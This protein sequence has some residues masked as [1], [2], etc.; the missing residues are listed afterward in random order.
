MYYSK[1]EKMKR[2]LLLIL[3]SIIFVGCGKSQVRSEIEAKRESR[4]MARKEREESRAAAKESR[5]AKLKAREESQAIAEAVDKE[6]HDRYD[7]VIVDNDVVKITL[8]T[9]MTSNNAMPCIIKNKTNEKITLVVFP[10][11]IT[12]YKSNEKIRNDHSD[13][14]PRQLEPNEEIL[15]TF[16]ITFHQRENL[17]LNC[18]EDYFDSDNKVHFR[19]NLKVYESYGGDL[20][21]VSEVSNNPLCDEFMVFDIYRAD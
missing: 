13:V 20:D 3:V 17:G 21:K 16:Y 1:G 6:I 4:E 8:I 7:K 10:T 2:V 14:F 18:Y 15:A 11:Y 19:T 9:K 12:T 5:E